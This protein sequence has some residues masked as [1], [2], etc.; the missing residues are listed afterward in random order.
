MDGETEVQKVTYFV[1]GWWLM[2]WSDPCLQNPRSP[3]LGC[4]VSRRCKSEEG[5]LKPPG[6]TA[7]S[8]RGDAT[9]SEGLDV[10]G[11]RFRTQ[12]TANSPGIKH[13]KQ[14]R[15]E[16]GE[17]VGCVVQIPTSQVG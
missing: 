2:L 5:G 13:K 16:T 8:Q 11:R 7:A 17:M 4:T 12:R 15:A 14:V 6:G 10:E 9:V 3:S 1:S